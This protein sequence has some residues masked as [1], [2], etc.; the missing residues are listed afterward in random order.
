MTKASLRNNVK[1]LAQVIEAEDLDTHSV[2]L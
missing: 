2:L 1:S